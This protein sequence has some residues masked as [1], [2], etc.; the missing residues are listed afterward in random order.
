MDETTLGTLAVLIDNRSVHAHARAEGWMRED[1]PGYSPEDEAEIGELLQ[2]ALDKLLQHEPLTQAELAASRRALDWYH[3]FPEAQHIGLAPARA[4]LDLWNSP[5]ALVSWEEAMDLGEE[6]FYRCLI[7]NVEEVMEPQGSV[8]FSV[9]RTQQLTEVATGPAWSE[10]VMQRLRVDHSVL[11]AQIRS[12][13]ASG[14]VDE[15][16]T[17]VDQLIEGLEWLRGEVTGVER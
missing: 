16:V 3:E 2:S 11:L 5:E 6:L 8:G 15:V 13:L 17:R 1:T 10:N 12:F 9:V 7:E 14:D 4:F